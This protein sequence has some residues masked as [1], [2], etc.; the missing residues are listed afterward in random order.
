MSND[1]PCSGLFRA[2]GSETRLVLLSLTAQSG[3]T[4]A[5]ELAKDVPVSRQS[6]GKHLAVLTRE[7]LLTKERRGR[8]TFYSVDAG[9]LFAAVA[10]LG[11]IGASLSV[12]A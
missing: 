3:R 2:L 1:D 9:A 10:W 7:G 5:T 12:A 11:E 6:V 4:T 8:Q